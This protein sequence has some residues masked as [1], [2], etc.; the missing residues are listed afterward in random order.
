MKVPPSLTAAPLELDLGP[1]VATAGFVVRDHDAV[2]AALSGFSVE[3][4]PERAVAK[5]RAE[6][7]AGRWAARTA[8]SA[9]GFDATPARREDG[10]PSWP[11][12]VVGS[13]THGAERAQ[14]AVASSERLRSIGIDAERLMAEG[15]SAELRARICSSAE[16]AVLAA[17]I[18]APE[19]HLVTF[20]FSAKE[21]L[22]KCLYPLM[23]RFMDFGAARV[24]AAEAQVDGVR[25]VGE[26]TLELS[27]DWS[28]EL[29]QGLRLP[30]RF[31]ATERHVE[32]A[33]LLPA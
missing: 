18:A 15:A 23:G 27:V 21:S 12:Q 24:V 8:L 1:A 32:S 28:V 10:T 11:A 22:Y 7:L 31:V 17:S 9:L 5:R 29:R 20:A 19:H 30:A 6:F 26:L 25:V 16:R 3:G 13:I 2:L 33:V 4:L 14:C